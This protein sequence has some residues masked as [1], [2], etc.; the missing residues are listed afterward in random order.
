MIPPV[1]LLGATLSVGLLC[2]WLGQRFR[3]P[4]VP[5][6]LLTGL[7]AQLWLG[8]TFALSYPLEIPLLGLACGIVFFEGGR[9]LGVQ[10]MGE[11]SSTILHL[12][13]FGPKVGW[14]L[15]SGLAYLCLGLTGHDALLLGAILLIASPYAV[16][17]F[18]DLVGGDPVLNRV[19]V[20]ESY[21]VSCV[22]CAWTVLMVNGLAAHIEHPN[23]VATLLATLA[24]LL[25]G[26]A[27]GWIGAR[28]IGLLLGSGQVADELADPLL[29]VGVI[30]CFGCAQAAYWGGGVV[31]AA[32]F[33]YR[34]AQDS[35]GQS[36]VGHL[37]PSLRILLLCFLGL[38]LGFHLPVQALC[39][40]WPVQLAFALAICVLL[41][42][43]LVYLGARKS[44]LDPQQ[45]RWAAAIHPRGILTLA[46]AAL[47][48]QRLRS[49]GESQAPALLAAVFWTV[50]VSQLLPW[51]LS[52]LGPRRA[53]QGPFD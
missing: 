31:S 21:L 29:Y 17:P 22:G 49:L 39:Q 42:P 35:R 50:M 38:V 18:V 23:L 20:W 32:Y 7:A 44:P 26:M 40:N 5:L 53:T 52:R 46:I 1:L 30:L 9:E 11:W 41:R 37:G 14:L 16:P 4:V 25:V 19:L 24:T 48:A 51:A 10:P 45:K 13:A 36:K 47:V 6:L 15:A 28:L 3:L 2:Y 8:P 27:C 43:L 33:G 34:F 12:A